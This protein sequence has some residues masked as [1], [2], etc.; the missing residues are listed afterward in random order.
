MSESDDL[1]V[2]GDLELHTCKKCGNPIMQRWICDLTGEDY[3][4]CDTC[5]YR[6]D[7]E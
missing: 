6:E 1:I 2:Y 7:K 5:N 3:W 4:I